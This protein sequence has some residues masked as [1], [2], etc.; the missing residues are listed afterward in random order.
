MTNTEGKKRD[1][2]AEVVLGQTTNFN[3]MLRFRETLRIQ[4]KFKGTIEATGALIVDRGAMVEADRIQ[5]SSL[6]VYGT[7][8]GDVHAADKNTLPRLLGI[9][10]ERTQA[11][12]KHIAELDARLEKTVAEWEDLKKNEIGLSVLEKESRSFP[13]QEQGKE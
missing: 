12:R 6:I 3:G 1:A 9:I 4:G 5:V 8:V 2:T 11:V 7:V 13:Q 10:T